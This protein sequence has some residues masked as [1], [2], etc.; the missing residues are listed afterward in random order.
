VSANPVQEEA[1]HPG[2]NPQTSVWNVPKEDVH[3]LPHQKVNPVNMFVARV[4]GAGF[5]WLFLLPGF[6][7]WF[8]LYRYRTR[9]FPYPLAAVV[10]GWV[11]FAFVAFF[12]FMFI[13][14]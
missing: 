7:S 5:G 14:A 6:M 2:V 9:Q 10:L 11:T 13:A 4:F 1:A 12:T 8:S 3:L